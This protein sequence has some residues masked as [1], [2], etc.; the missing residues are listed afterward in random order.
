M[1][2]FDQDSPI[3]VEERQHIEEQINLFNRRFSGASVPVSKK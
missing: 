2:R 3:P 1:K